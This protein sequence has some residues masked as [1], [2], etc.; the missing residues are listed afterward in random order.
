MFEKIAGCL[1]FCGLMLCGVAAE[2]VF[3]GSSTPCEA[4]C[5]GHCNARPAVFPNTGHNCILGQPGNTCTGTTQDGGENCGC[6]EWSR[7]SGD[8][9]GNTIFS[10]R[11][12]GSPIF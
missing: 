9:M 2:P 1:V 5:S 11:C 8:G 12:E 4:G 6:N 7:P 10:C 3:A